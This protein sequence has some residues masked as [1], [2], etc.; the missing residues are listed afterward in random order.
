[1]TGCVL[2]LCAS[3]HSQIRA[4]NAASCRVDDGDDE[5]C[6]DGAVLEE[7]EGDKRVAGS[8]ALPE[9][10]ADDEEAAAGE[11]SDRVGCMQSR[12]QFL[13]KRSDG[14]EQQTSRTVTPVRTLAVGDSDNRQ[15]H[16]EAGDEE[17]ETDDVELPEDG[18]SALL[19]G[20]LGDAL[21]GSVLD[22]LSLRLA[23]T[24]A[25]REENRSRANGYDDAFTRIKKGHNQRGIL[26]SQTEK[27]SHHMPMPQ[28]HMFACWLRDPRSDWAMLPETQT[29]MVCEA[30]VSDRGLQSFKNTTDADLHRGWK[31]RST[32]KDGC[33]WTKCRR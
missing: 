20:L 26:A 7:T 19:Q 29:L 33:E 6:D 15:K 27:Y 14:T 17:Q 3:R 1:M 18:E 31:G 9:D 21:L 11:E 28:R 12:D 8:E 10:E 5:A 24:D 4:D 13:R 16:A 23:H 25:E 30:R 22:M 2:V 32:R